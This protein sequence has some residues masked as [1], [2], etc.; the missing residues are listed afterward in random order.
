LTPIDIKPR[1]RRNTINPRSRGEVAVA[2]L[3]TPSFDAPNDVDRTSLTFGKTGDEASLDSC[4][5]RARD[6]NRD[7]LPDLV[8]N[9]TIRLAGFED[10]DPE[11]ILRGETVSGVLFEGRDAVRV[12]SPGPR[13]RIRPRDE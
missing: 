9:F 1:D 8:C 6:V 3:S 10:G 7:G 5:S 11:G 4:N 2:I 13:S 12:E